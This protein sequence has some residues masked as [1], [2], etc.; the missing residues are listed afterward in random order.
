MPAA[1]VGTTTPE[2]WNAWRG[3]NALVDDGVVIQRTFGVPTVVHEAGSDGT[4]DIALD[5]CERLY[6]LTG[7]GTIR[8]YDTGTRD[9]RHY[10]DFDGDGVADG[11]AYPR[12]LC[13]HEGT[14][15]IA[16]GESA[17]EG[18]TGGR[19]F[20]VP[21]RTGLARELD[22]VAS[23]ETVALAASNRRIYLLDGGEG[24]GE[25]TVL[26]ID[27]AG[28]VAP[29]VVVDGLTAP[30]DLAVGGDGVLAV[31]DAGG[32]ESEDGA[33]G[34][35]WRV[36]VFAVGRGDDGGERVAPRPDVHV[37]D[38]ERL[39][40]DASRLV[41]QAGEDD[42]TLVVVGAV[43]ETEVGAVRRY[44]LSEAFDE[45]VAV[46]ADS[47]PLRPTGLLAVQTSTSRAGAY[48]VVDD[49]T[50]NV[51]LVVEAGRNRRNESTG[52]F[53]AR[54]VTRFDSGISGVRWHRVTLDVG[55]ERVGV[56]TVE[57]SSQVRL[58]Y[59][60]TDDDD[61]GDVPIESVPGIGPTYARRLRNAGVAWSSQLTGYDADRLAAIAAASPQRVGLLRTQARQWLDAAAERAVPWKQTPGPNPRDSLVDATGRYLWVELELVG[62][63][64]ASPRVRELRAFFPRESYLRYLPSIYRADE[65]SAGFLERYL[66]IPESDFES[67][68]RN[69]DTLTRYLDR[70]GV[71][72]ESLSWLGRWIGIKTDE[73]WP[74][75]V[76]RAFVVNAPSLFERRGTPTGLLSMLR[77]YLDAN[78]GSSAVVDESDDSVGENDEHDGLD[79]DSD[80]P[81]G[82]EETADEDPTPAEV[83]AELARAVAIW[84]HADLDPIA[85]DS[86]AREPYRRLVNSPA[87]FV[88]LVGPSVT[89]E[90]VTALERLVETETPIHAVGR[91]ARLTP[92]IR[93]GGHS[94]LGLNTALATREFVV[95]RSSLG[96][97]SMLWEHADSF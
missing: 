33:D 83:A 17:D 91:V 62:S 7:D 38:T 11:F 6:V 58:R 45:T 72:S 95:D 3:T 75:S 68:E 22:G 82:G 54:L 31:L 42:R 60:A 52:R 90:E 16:T 43:D 85:P 34:D 14:M 4:V 44:H 78:A 77:L 8:R 63:E 49:D 80:G 41:V 13:L 97:D 10:R 9:V 74:D 59:G 94:Y 19:L 89:D 55:E 61:V 25:G 56:G 65:K 81:G 21:R 30:R 67:I 76:R 39:T 23:A 28:R 69:V 73:T 26:Q 15:Y 70:E 46:T 86:P 48:Y 36:R 5:P 50:E 24:R 29:T 12:A 20:A 32:D 92:W 64:Y 93:L 88:V 37:S 40:L 27:P 1:F 2:A 87:G 79:G 51:A 66:S 35:P 71:P 53:D 47:L 96:V 57:S 18:R 84:E